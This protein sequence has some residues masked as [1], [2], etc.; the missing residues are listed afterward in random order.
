MCEMV[1]TTKT[2]FALD[3]CG[4]KVEKPDLDIQH[5]GRFKYPEHIIIQEKSE[6]NWSVVRN[7][8]SQWQTTVGILTGDN[9]RVSQ[10]LSYMVLAHSRCSV[11]VWGKSKWVQLKSYCALSSRPT[12]HGVHIPPG[13][14]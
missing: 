7:P 2:E 13:P 8:R 4:T 1:P 10:L 11:M 5:N 14:R 12:L 3:V 6:G 9:A